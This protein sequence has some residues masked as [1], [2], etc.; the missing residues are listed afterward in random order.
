MWF[1]N[2]LFLSFHHS[3]HINSTITYGD[4]DYIKVYVLATK[5]TKK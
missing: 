5:S 4:G 2:I 1:L 3:N